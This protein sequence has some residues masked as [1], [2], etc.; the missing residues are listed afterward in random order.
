M[1][2][3]GIALPTLASRLSSQVNT[4]PTSKHITISKMETNRARYRPAKN[5]SSHNVSGPAVLASAR[6]LQKETELLDRVVRI[7]VQQL[8]E[9]TSHKLNGSS[10][11]CERPRLGFRLVKINPNKLTIHQ[12]RVAKM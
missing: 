7:L 4:S 9:S 5:S 8:N 1:L 2:V 3:D 12:T 11:K 10:G 6:A